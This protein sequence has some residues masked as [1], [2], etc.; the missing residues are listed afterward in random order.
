M[1]LMKKQFFDAIRTGAKTTTLRYWEYARVR[2]NSVH[3]VQGLGRLRIDS[4]AP[5]C[6]ESLDEV[7]AVADGFKSIA[8]LR[9]AL[10]ALYPPE[11]RKGRQLYRV[12]FTFIE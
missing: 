6:L 10:K 3:R 5:V 12:R 7:D 8:A 11:C 2:P 1:L 4:I 9:R